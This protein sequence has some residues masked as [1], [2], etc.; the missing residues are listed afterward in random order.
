MSKKYD[1]L[2]VGAGIAGTM[3]GAILARKGLKVLMIEKGE[4]PRYAIGESTVP[5]SSILMTFLGVK[6]DVPEFHQLGLASKNGIDTKVMSTNGLKRAFGFVHHEQG[7]ELDPDHFFQWGNTYR[8]ENHLFREDVDQYLLYTAIRYGAEYLSAT[9]IT[10]V[11]VNDERVFVK[12]KE[13]AEFTADFIYDSSG[14]NSL[15]S[16]NLKLREEPTRLR[17]S[18]RS[19]F[20]H[21][22][23]VKPFEEILPTGPVPWSKTTLHHLFDGG[24]IWVIAMNNHAKSNNPLISIGY[25]LQTDK[26]GM[27]PPRDA[28]AEFKSLLDKLPTAAKQF[29]NA[30]L[31]RRWVATGRLQY[32]TRQMVGDRFCLAAHCAGSVDALFSR[33]LV[34]TLEVTRSLVDPLLAAFKDGV[35]KRERFEIV[36]QRFFKLL[37]WNDSLVR[38]AVTSWREFEVWNAFLR[39]WSLS[40]L[41]MENNFFHNM[42]A[43]HA[44]L[45]FEPEDLEACVRHIKSIGNDSGVVANPLLHEFEEPDYARFYTRVSDIMERYSQRTLSAPETKELLQQEIHQHIDA[46]RWFPNPMV[47]QMFKNGIG[48]VAARSH[49]GPPRR[50]GAAHGPPQAA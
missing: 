40:V 31:V 23:D 34:N 50:D 25:T 32:S 15:L 46:S 11:D 39:V 20:T 8:D 3:M 14:H 19:G 28:E 12:T 2:I 37:A 36:E 16:Q 7:K 17:Q 49:Y 9:T 24:W 22:I 30:K 21:M 43:G 35:F 26:Y 10:E 6:Y 4:H 45:T 48:N 44:P 1:V 41:G 18:S 38:Q 27:A 33:G 13:G 29:E 47:R 42:K 5:M